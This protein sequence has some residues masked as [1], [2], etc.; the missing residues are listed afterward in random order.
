MFEKGFIWNLSNFESECDKACDVG[1]Y[2]TM[3]IVSAVKS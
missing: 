1:E 2:L 3:E